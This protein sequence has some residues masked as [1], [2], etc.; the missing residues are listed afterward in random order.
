MKMVT[1]TF[2]K[3]R[4]AMMHEIEWLVEYAL[5]VGLRFE[6]VGDL[7]RVDGFDIAFSCKTPAALYS[8]YLNDKS[9][10]FSVTLP[11]RY[12]K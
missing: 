8:A 9:I 10:T 3:P 5:A 6:L 1:K 4:Y 11:A 2:E 12:W 7:C